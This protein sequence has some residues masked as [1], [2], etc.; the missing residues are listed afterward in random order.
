VPP[1]TSGE[2][3][4]ATQWEDL[5]SVGQAG[6][7]DNFFD[8]GG[9]SLHATQLLARL[10]SQLGV[11]L[12]L[13]QVFMTPVLEDL[14]A[15]IDQ[16]GHE[17]GSGPAAVTPDGGLVAFRS[18][19]TRAPLFLIH[20]VGGS[21]TC[22][23]QLAQALGDDQPVYGI[24]D[25]GLRGE[26]A[27]DDL[28][29]RARQYTGLIRARQPH[30]PYLVGGWSYGGWIAQEMGCQ[31]A[32]AGEDVSVFALDT[33][34]H[35]EP[36]TPTDIEIGAGFVTDVAGIAGAPLPGIDLASLET[37][38]R[39]AL[40]NLALDTL[41][42][43]GV[44]TPDMRADLRTRMLAFETNYRAAL[45]HQAQPFGGP[46]VLIT[47]AGNTATRNGAGWA[48]LAPALDHRTAGGD[49]YSMLRAPH[50]AGL[51]AT[52]RD[53]LAGAGGPHFT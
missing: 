1:R 2:R 47:A 25:P 12:N 29:R 43:A 24:E 49:H 31:L 48:A 36:R 44:A 18:T 41:I 20:P 30:G 21:A 39:T 14:A 17:S 51:A 35:P 28:A 3:W 11:H 37:M 22:Y 8:L 10:I 50:L 34:A 16:A 46:A 13:R 9:N 23:A 45:S 27:T 7:E 4:L 42:T 38:D 40:E 53:A 52:L 6:A 26:P 5:L 19:G 32:A 15:L 33:G